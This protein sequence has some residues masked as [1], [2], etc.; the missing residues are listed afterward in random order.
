MKIVSIK[1]SI[2]TTR[3]LHRGFEQL[4]DSY[5]IAETINDPIIQ[6]A[7]YFLQT[8]LIK[9]KIAQSPQRREAYN[10]ILNS[11][12]PFL[13]LE[14]PVFRRFPE[15]KYTRLGWWSYKW[16]DGIFGNENSPSDRWN[17]FSKE[18]GIVLKDWHSPGDSILIMC[19]KEGDSSLINLYSKY[20]SYYDWVEDI[21]LQI[22]KYSD[23]PIIIR[24]HPRN[25]SAGK[26]LASKLVKKNK[27]IKVS[28][29]VLVSNKKNFD[30][31]GDGLEQD[32]AQAHCV[33]TYNSL[34]G[35]E[36][37]SDGIP[38]F[39]LDGGSMVSPV[40][41]N[42]LSQIENLDYEIDRTQWCNDVAYTHWTTKE[43]RTG[44]SWAHLK[45]L[46]FGK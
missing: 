45:P 8:N 30:Y 24:P 21:I 19:Q 33:I 6:D 29:N 13:V 22:R 3:S 41:H 27:N 28:E 23:R 44:E 42:D 5:T 43:N 34:S 14:S 1:G 12:K 36:S 32:F 26:K 25:Y 31:Q 4:G 37:V 16:N 9:P 20:N 46:M 39:A 15:L 7:D 11:K 18:S 17:K 38:T 10:Y 40:T 35:V 2:K